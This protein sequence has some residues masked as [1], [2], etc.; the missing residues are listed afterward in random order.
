MQLRTLLIQKQH[1]GI[2]LA[3][4]ILVCLSI[5]G[6]IGLAY[7]LI[8]IGKGDIQNPHKQEKLEKFNN[9]ALFITILISV[10]NVIVNVFMSTTNAQSF[11]E[12]AVLDSSTISTWWELA[13]RWR[14]ISVIE[15][16][17]C[18]RHFV[19]RTEFTFLCLSVYLIG[20]TFFLHSLN[21]ASH[22]LPSVLLLLLLYCARQESWTQYIHLI[23]SQMYWW[24]R[25]FFL[26]SMWR[27]Q[28][29]TSR[30]GS[31]RSSKSWNRNACSMLVQME[32]VDILLMLCWS[33]HDASCWKNQ[34]RK[35][36]CCSRQHL[37]Q[38]S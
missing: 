31:E 36:S 19:S 34:E 1:D 35:S 21:L 24:N 2:W 37:F 38:F 32:V 9:L 30:R 8:I 12:P 16:I 22:F 3:S 10:I 15:K 5:I 28:R 27:F 18:L 6:Q 7:I 13:V 33:V 17:C 29:R 26:L 20:S 14:K 11:F 23:I 4:L 25:R